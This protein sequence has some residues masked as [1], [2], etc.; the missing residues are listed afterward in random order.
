MQ[1][2]ELS[3]RTGVPSKTIRYYEAIGVM[4]VP[5]RNEN[6]YRRYADDA[7]AR[8]GFVRAAQSVGLTLG[9]IREVLAFRDR[10]ENPC[11]HVA[12]L[13]DRHA[14]DLGERILALQA[15]HRDLGRLAQRARRPPTTEAGAQFCH[16][17]EG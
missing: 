10:G 13:I 7:S 4:P 14:A 8:L 17:I 2:G 3:D 1:I 6:G 11:R 15:M 5:A 12:Q 16:I 9:E